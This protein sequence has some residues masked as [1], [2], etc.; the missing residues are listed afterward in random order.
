MHTIA[1]ELLGTDP[2]LQFDGLLQ[3]TDAAP[4]QIAAPAA[5]QAVDDVR[6][7]LAVTV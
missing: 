2:V 3:F 4:V 6:L 1:F 5:L 7:K